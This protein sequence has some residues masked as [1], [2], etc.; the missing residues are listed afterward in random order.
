MMGFRGFACCLLSLPFALTLSVACNAQSKAPLMARCSD[1]S[2]TLTSLHDL[3]IPEK[4]LAACRKGTQLFTAKDSAGSIAEFQ[5]AIKIFPDYYEAYAELGAAELDLDHWEHAESDFRESLDL[6]QGRYAPADFG[7]GLIL[8]TVERRFAAA[9]GVV[10]DGLAL[11]PNDVTGRFVLAWVLYCTSR[12]REAEQNALQALQFAPKFAGAQLLLAQ[13]H[14]GQHN[15]PAAIDDMSTYLSFGAG[16]P[17]YAKVQ[18]VRTQAL[19][20][21]PLQRKAIAD[22]QTADGSNHSDSN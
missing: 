2:A 13:I 4:A 10:Q 7:L 21:L 22:S 17:L 3:R 14:L 15:L 20:E 8:A 1:A 6:S 5:K 9:E 16:S 19:R 12:L 18:E 11:D